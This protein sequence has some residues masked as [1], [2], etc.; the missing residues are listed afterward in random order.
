[1]RKLLL[2]STALV[3]A[4]MLAAPAMAGTPTV[5]D[6]FS[7]S[8]GGN[9][10]FSLLIYDQDRSSG[11]GQGYLLKS[12]ESEVSFKARGTA[13]NGL[14][15]GFDLEIQTQTNDTTNADETWMFIDGGDAWG[16]VEL[17][18]QDDAADRMHVAGED[19]MDAGRGGY[20]GAV[21]DVFNFGSGGI[22]KSPSLSPSSDATKII[23][24]TPRFGGV[25]LGASWTPD[26]GQIG[27]SGPSDN[28]GDFSN[29]FSLGVN[30]QNTFN[31]TGITVSG[32]YFGG[33]GEPNTSG[34]ANTGTSV[35]DV[36]I[37]A[38]G[39]LVTFAGFEFGVGYADHN[40]T[41]LAEPTNGADK[42]TW[43]DVGLNYKTGP[44][45]VGAGYFHGEK[46]YA[47]TVT[48][49]DAEVDIFSIGFDYSVAPGWK[50]ESDINFIEAE[51]IDT[52]GTDN[53]GTVFVLS[54]TM[55]F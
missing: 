37:W 8:I 38:V 41:G 22:M 5:G 9:L 18:D 29:V 25:Q 17:G 32:V 47:N 49:G 46:D 19:A 16:R 28:D 30:Y 3:G 31:G 20:N 48:T 34:G 15:Y 26:N 6:D 43:W 50:I 7:V 1:M 45:T 39:A 12:G 21:G 14:N 35:E 27:G 55:S 52:T 10:R 4:S 23:Y 40:D 13:E 33:D 51:N 44:W 54:S 42:G 53:D 11:R 2:A 24:F 36:E